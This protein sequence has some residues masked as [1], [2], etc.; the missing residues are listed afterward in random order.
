MDCFPMSDTSYF[1]Y[2]VQFSS[3]LWQ[4]NTF[5]AVYYFI[6]GTRVIIQKYKPDDVTP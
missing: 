2:F 5:Y 4:K 1:M 6:R 3:Y